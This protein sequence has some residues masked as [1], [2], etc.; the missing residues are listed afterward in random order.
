MIGPDQ[1][2]HLLSYNLKISLRLIKKFFEDEI[3]VRQRLITSRKIFLAHSSLQPNQK[4]LSM[5]LSHSS[6]KQNISLDRLQQTFQMINLSV[7]DMPS[8][9]T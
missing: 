7:S 2:R 1:E 4:N 9:L 5:L 3:L 6:V 8:L